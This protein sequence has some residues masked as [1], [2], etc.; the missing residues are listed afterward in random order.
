MNKTVPVFKNF[1]NLVGYRYLNII[2]P[3]HGKCKK[4]VGLCKRV[5]WDHIKR[6]IKQK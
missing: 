6:D 1:H 5:L 4:L 3:P 2:I